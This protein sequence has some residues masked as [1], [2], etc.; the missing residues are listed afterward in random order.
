MSAPAFRLA[1]PEDEAALKA[2]FETAYAE[3]VPVIAKRPA[4]MDDPVAPHIAAGHAHLAK[5]DGRVAAALIGWPKPEH[6]PDHFYVFNI[7]AAPDLRGRGLGS[8]LLAHA[9]A[10]AR[11]A[12]L[13]AIELF[14]NKLMTTNIA[15]YLAKGFTITG[16]KREDGF[17]RVYFRKQLL[18]EP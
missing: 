10:L 16:E 9:E 13:D 6:S 14:T 3:Y 17:E 15:M 7:A 11:A 2:L 8:A 18:A 1:R 4:P 12:G 5:L